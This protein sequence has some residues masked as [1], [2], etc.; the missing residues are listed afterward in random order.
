MLKMTKTNVPGH[1]VRWIQAW[2][3]N[4]LAWVTYDGVPSKRVTLK[5]GVPQG[6]VLS[7]LLFLFYINDLPA[8]I[9]DAEIS[10]FADDVA[11]WVKGPNLAANQTKLQKALDAVSAWSSQWKMEISAQKSES[12][13]FS[14]NTHEADW[15]PTVQLNGH[16]IPYNATPKFLG[17]TFDRQP[18]FGTHAELVGGK[19][20]RQ[21]G[22]LRCLA[23]T[24]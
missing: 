15:K 8:R 13:F 3:T 12:S 14:S 17:V 18:T 16:Q 9:E 5:Q 11:V 21:V 19:T 2:L 23:S 24:D 20:K 4:R 7:P 1:M 6:S 22:A 10:L